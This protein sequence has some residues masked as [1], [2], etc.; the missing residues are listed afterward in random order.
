M[1][2][3]TELVRVFKNRPPLFTFRN[4]TI[5]LCVHDAWYLSQ[6]VQF[7]YLIR[8]TYFTKGDRD[9]AYMKIIKAYKAFKKRERRW[10]KNLNIPE[11]PKG[12]HVD[13]EIN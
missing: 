9:E 10:Y 3:R 6:V 12:I 2:R 1:P 5:A 4:G 7:K 11:P 13:T 8:E